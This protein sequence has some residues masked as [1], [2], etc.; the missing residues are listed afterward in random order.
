VSEL[1]DETAEAQVVGPE[2]MAPLGDA[3]RLVDGEQGRLRGAQRLDR[4]RSGQLLGSEE[5][6]LELVLP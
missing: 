4:L 3:V 5:E 1:L 2:V 6:E